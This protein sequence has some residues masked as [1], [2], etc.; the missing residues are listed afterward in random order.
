MANTTLVGPIRIPQ[1][2]RN[3]YVGEA[4]LQT[5]QQAVNF[6]ITDS[7]AGCVIIPQDYT[8]TDAISAVTAGSPT[9]YIMDERHGQR[10]IYFWYLNAYIHGS[11]HALGG[12]LTPQVNNYAYVGFGT[13]PTIQGVI[14]GFAALP[15]VTVTIIVEASYTGSEV[16]GNLTNG[17]PGIVISDQ[18]TDQ[19]QNYR[20]N[21]TNFVPSDFEPMG[22]IIA[23]TITAGDITADSIETGTATFDDCV[24]DNSPVRTFANTP[25]G[26][27]QGMV[28]P[29][30]GI[31]VSLG[32]TW[33]SPSIDPTDIAY[34]DHTNVFSK[35]QTFNVEGA[36][37]N[38]RGNV[39]LSGINVAQAGGTWSWN[40]SQNQAETSFTNVGS[41]AGSG[42]FNWYNT[43]TASGG[44]N[45]P[46]KLMGVDSNGNL[47]AN[48]T[49]TTTVNNSGSNLITAPA[50]GFVVGWN[51][52]SGVGATD[53]VNSHGGGGG[54][55]YWW[56]VAQGTV[57][58]PG[59]TPHMI[60]DSGGGLNLPLGSVS[61]ASASAAIQIAH[62]NDV[63]DASVI[64]PRLFMAVNGQSGRNYQGNFVF[65]TAA[66]SGLSAQHQLTL[67]HNA[68]DTGTNF[69]I[70]GL[71]EQLC[72]I[73]PPVLSCA[74]ASLRM[75]ARQ[76]GGW[77]SGSPNINSDNISLVL[78]PSGTGT[79]LL[80]WDMGTGGIFFGNGAQNVVGSVDTNGDATFN[81]V[82]TAGIGTPG[83]NTWM[84]GN[85]LVAG[86]GA[87]TIGRNNGGAFGSNAEFRQDNSIPRTYLDSWGEFHIN[88]R[89]GGTTVLTGLFQVNGTK[90]FRIAHPFKEKTYLVHSTVEG[91]EVA[92][93]YRGEGE[94]VNGVVTI[95]LPD[96]FEALTRPEGRTVQLTERY[97]DED[98]P[99]FG[100]FLAA[101]R[102]K[103]GK[104]NVRSNN[105]T[106]KF[107]WEVKAVRS[108]VEPLEVEPA[109]SEEDHKQHDQAGKEP[110]PVAPQPATAETKKRGK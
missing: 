91:P 32:S 86:N 65:Q 90:N 10:Q 80:N 110:E 102:V 61:L 93:F 81:G 21:G 87:I 62:N 79:T 57:V 37:M 60:L 14:D 82:V 4:M 22:K 54:A 99:Q 109:W 44:P 89:Q 15:T 39:P 6:A 47:A 107:Y 76:N 92:V 35:D 5:I 72:D 70:M 73:H 66:P 83:G 48:G 19:W 2:N 46:R 53:F 67:W 18:R 108:D 40:A 27:G 31:P 63:A 95:T 29:D 7:N 45:P 36:A 12:V 94:T 101:G 51:A 28:W 50:A 52:I 17:D 97:D 104:F 9:V 26:P 77:T 59:I 34:L 88:E 84:D 96:Y 24:V 38:I 78:N 8:G 98:N 11:I 25:D 3:Y 13:N 69:Y 75:G 49:I 16:I 1:V 42:G 68:A 85:R 58:G 23:T 30:I 33:Q 106:A 100:N 43:W 74:S 56:N 71:S 103:D 41:A 64:T 105:G 20:W 55:F